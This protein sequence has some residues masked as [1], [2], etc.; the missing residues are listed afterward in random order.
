MCAVSSI[1]IR[2][3]IIR[4]CIM[5][6]WRREFSRN[7]FVPVAENTT[8][9]LRYFVS[10]IDIHY[11]RTWDGASLKARNDN[12]C[13][14]CEFIA[15]VSAIF[16]CA[17]KPTMQKLSDVFICTIYVRLKS[18]FWKKRNTMRQ[19]YHYINRTKN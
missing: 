18:T 1:K 12:M 2:F 9:G 19:W 13:G 3:N 17:V 16:M 10:I 7:F 6:L 5:I 14:Y 15:I 8:Q 4:F 11:I